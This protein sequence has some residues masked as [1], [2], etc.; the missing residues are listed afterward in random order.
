VEEEDE[1]EED[2]PDLVSVSTR[3]DKNYFFE[4]RTLV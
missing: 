2:S 4:S 1:E 3:E